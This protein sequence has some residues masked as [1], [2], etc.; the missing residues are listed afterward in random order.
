MSLIVGPMR[1]PRL[2]HVIVLR[3]KLELLETL[4]SVL[5]EGET[6]VPS[7]C[8]WGESWQAGVGEPREGGGGTVP[9]TCMR[10]F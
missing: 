7:P 8:F 6:H 2:G 10:G 4:G 5:F 1:W 3:L 9:K